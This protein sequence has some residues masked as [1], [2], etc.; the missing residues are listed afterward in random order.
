[1]VM[2][3][4]QDSY[5]AKTSKRRKQT[6]NMHEFQSLEVFLRAGTGTPRHESSINDCALQCQEKLETET[7]SQ[8]RSQAFKF[9]ANFISRYFVLEKKNTQFGKC[10]FAITVV[11]ISKFSYTSKHFQKAFKKAHR[12]QDLADDFQN[13][14][15]DFQNL[16]DDFQVEISGSQPNQGLFHHWFPHLSILSISSTCLFP[17]QSP[18]IPY[19][20]TSFVL[21]TYMRRRQKI[22]FKGARKKNLHSWTVQKC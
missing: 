9:F 20:K 5:V 2:S 11:F 8:A 15:D 16:A 10:W 4:R 1:M 21:K 18:G 22:S 12:N 6:Y 7:R 19:L 3:R 17:I 13:L 14:A